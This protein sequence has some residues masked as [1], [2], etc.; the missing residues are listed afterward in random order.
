[1]KAYIDIK[2][3]LVYFWKIRGSVLVFMK[4]LVS[5]QCYPMHHT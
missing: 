5:K 4:Y 2:Y 1:M 3:F